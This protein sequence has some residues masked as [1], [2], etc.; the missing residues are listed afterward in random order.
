MPIRLSTSSA[1]YGAQVWFVFSSMAGRSAHKQGRNT[2]EKSAPTPEIS[3]N[4]LIVNK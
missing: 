1:G 4:A 2:S 3:R